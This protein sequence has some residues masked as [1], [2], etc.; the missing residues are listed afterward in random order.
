MS[1]AAK[2]TLPFW[3]LPIMAGKGVGLTA[4]LLG[5]LR[6]DAVR[7]P[8]CRSVRD[9]RCDDIRGRASMAADCLTFQDWLAAA[10]PPPT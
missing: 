4:L 10:I 5:R 8:V 7:R 3:V 9:H 2:T 1:S 6:H